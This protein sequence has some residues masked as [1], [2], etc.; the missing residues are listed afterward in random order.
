MSGIGLTQT[1]NVVQKQKLILT[2]HLRLFLS[3]D[4]MNTVEL[5]EYLEEQLI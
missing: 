1:P 3:L 5:G 2:Q 4:Q